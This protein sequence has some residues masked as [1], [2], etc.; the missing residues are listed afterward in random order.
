MTP[1]ASASIVRA[2]AFRRPAPTSKPSS[3][4]TRRTWDPKH[5][6]VGIESTATAPSGAPGADAEADTSLRPDQAAVAATPT[7]LSA[8]R[9]Q[10]TGSPTRYDGKR[11][12]AAKPYPQCAD[13]SSSLRR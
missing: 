9:K 7:G 13:A 10:C 6:A 11:A 12:V 4:M 8:A 2:A 3:A 5:A 1:G